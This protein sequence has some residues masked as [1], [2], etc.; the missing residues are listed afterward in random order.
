M[1]YDSWSTALGSKPSS[2]F[3]S[4]LKRYSST[5]MVILKAPTFGGHQDPHIFTNWL[6]AMDQFFEQ[7]GLLNDRESLVCQDETDRQSQRIL[8]Q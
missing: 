2:C 6:H 4:L 1:P 5:M 7:I 8:V 3:N